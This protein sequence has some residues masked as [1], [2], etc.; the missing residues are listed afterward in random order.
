MTS[1]NYVM[2]AECN[3]RGVAGRKLA[4]MHQKLNHPPTGKHHGGVR[5]RPQT[6]RTRL[7]LSEEKHNNLKKLGS[8][9]EAI[10]KII[11]ATFCLASR[12]YQRTQFQ[13]ASQN[14][15]QNPITFCHEDPVGHV[16]FRW[17]LGHENWQYETSTTTSKHHKKKHWPSFCD[18]CLSVKR[19]CWP[20]VGLKHCRHADLAR[21]PRESNKKKTLSRLTSKGRLALFICF[22]IHS[23]INW[24]FQKVAISVGEF[25]AY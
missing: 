4:S 15:V 17:R 25:L 8:K 24:I 18:F 12:Q 3:D 7:T 20:L 11:W 23:S 14:C 9:C 19:A 16:K 10:Q 2:A 13:L 1:Q 22:V 21:F 5:L 6:R